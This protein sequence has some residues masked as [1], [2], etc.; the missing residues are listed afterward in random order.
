MMQLGK[1][2][3]EQLTREKVDTIIEECKGL[4]V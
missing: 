3:K 4:K 2:Y 1:I